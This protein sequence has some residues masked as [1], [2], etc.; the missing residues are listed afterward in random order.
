MIDA[1][2]KDKWLEALRSGAYNQTTS[3]LKRRDEQGAMY[4]CCLGVLCD[5]VDP[6][7]WDDDL[8]HHGWCRMPSN[9]IREISGLSEYVFEVEELSEMNDK[10]SSFL[11][12]ADVIEQD[13]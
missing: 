1:D 2:I 6:E 10:G 13:L 3:R 4:Y 5:I 11:D 9:K 7:G 12:I 8:H